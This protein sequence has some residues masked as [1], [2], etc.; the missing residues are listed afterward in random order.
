MFCF[1]A[2]AATDN[3][4]RMSHSKLKPSRTFLLSLCK[5]L[6][7]EICEFIRQDNRYQDLYREK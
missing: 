6:T 5:I 4:V 2:L 3:S 1:P 7:V